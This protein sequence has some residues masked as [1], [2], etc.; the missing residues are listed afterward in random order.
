MFQTLTGTASLH[1]DKL[2]TSD[3]PFDTPTA[4]QGKAQGRRR[5][6]STQKLPC[7]CEPQAKHV[8][9]IAEGQSPR[10]YLGIASSQKPLLAMTLSW[11]LEPQL[12]LYLSA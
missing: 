2:S 11:F 6:V 1:F 7:H 8:L 9:S 4:T 12:V 5:S 3:K 10:S